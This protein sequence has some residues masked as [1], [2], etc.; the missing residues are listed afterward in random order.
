MSNSQAHLVT[1]LLEQVRE[2]D[3]AAET[4][5]L[6]LVYRELKEMARAQLAREGSKQHLHASTLVQEAYLRLFS[7]GGGQFHD[8]RYFFGA[9]SRAMRRIRIDYARSRKSLRRGSGQQPQQ[10]LA[11]PETLTDDVLDKLALEEALVK[12][13]G[14]M[15]R[16]AEI[17]QLRYFASLTIDQVAE[18]LSIAPRT[19]DA[20]WNMARAWLHRELIAGDD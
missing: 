10:L 6:E 11:D 19:V 9:A 7:P 12:L 8:R 20:E 3:K 14:E 16:A 2:G 15:P 13:E 4:S 1:R 5:L 17:V 18:V